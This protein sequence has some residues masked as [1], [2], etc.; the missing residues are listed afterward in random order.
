VVYIG[1]SFQGMCVRENG[2]RVFNFRLLRRN[3]DFREGLR[4]F[5]IFRIW[6][7]QGK[8]RELFTG[9]LIFRI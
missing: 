5:I 2:H 6:G 8:F 4:E 9:N 7:G 1:S 3:G